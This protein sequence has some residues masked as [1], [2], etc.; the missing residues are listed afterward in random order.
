[1]YRYGTGGPGDLG[2]RADP[3]RSGVDAEV[4]ADRSLHS[5]LQQTPLRRVARPLS[6]LSQDAQHQLGGHAAAKDAYGLFA[7][8]CGRVLRFVRLEAA[9]NGLRSE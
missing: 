7:Q 5:L 6:R 3:G 1:M 4:F 9:E 2:A 8:A